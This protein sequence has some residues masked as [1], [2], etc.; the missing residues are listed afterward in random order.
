MTQFLCQY[1]TSFFTVYTRILRILCRNTLQLQISEVQTFFYI[2]IWELRKKPLAVGSQITNFYICKIRRY[3]LNTVFRENAFVPHI[4]AISAVSV[5]AITSDDV[6]QAFLA[7][8]YRFP[9]PS[10]VGWR[11][12]GNVELISS[13]WQREEWLSVL[14]LLSPPR[15]GG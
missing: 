11:L 10:H 6:Y 13:Q 3:I 7:R 2:K 9:G 15:L 4:L 14:W 1:N 8:P 5:I 12:T